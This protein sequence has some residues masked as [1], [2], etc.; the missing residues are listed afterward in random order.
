MKMA[1]EEAFVQRAGTVR[2]EFLEPRGSMEFRL[3]THDSMDP[4]PNTSPSVV[5]HF[6]CTAPQWAK[7]YEKMGRVR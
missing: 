4:K 1:E 7:F 5:I 2:R 3:P 6:L